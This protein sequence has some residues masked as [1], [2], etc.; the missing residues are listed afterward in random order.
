MAQIFNAGESIMDSYFKGLESRQRD[1]K[2]K[3]ETEIA[4]QVALDRQQKM[5]DDYNRV[6]RQADQLERYQSDVIRNQQAAQ[7]LRSQEF[8]LNLGK[9]VA[10]G[11]ITRADPNVPIDANDPSTYIDN[12]VEAGLKVAA[13]RAGTIAGATANAQVPAAIDK[14][15][16]IALATTPIE[17]DAAVNKAMRI[18]EAVTKPNKVAENLHDDEQK[19]LDREAKKEAANIRASATYALAGATKEAKLD[20]TKNLADA[21]RDDVKSGST[22]LEDLPKGNVG[23]ALKAQLLNEGLKIPTKK[24]VEQF[25]A[26]K[27]LE[28]FHGKIRKLAD[29]I[30]GQTVWSAGLDSEITQR[31]KELKDDLGGMQKMKGETGVFSDKDMI[32]AAG[33][34]PE[35]LPGG[36][37]DFLSD[38]GRKVA[39]NRRADE[40]YDQM[41]QNMEGLTRN[42][43]EE[44]KTAV[45]ERYA[46]PPRQK[47][48]ATKP[49]K[50]L[51][52]YL[53]PAP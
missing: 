26:Q 33:G 50:E 23:V 37:R 27:I 22:A 43:P 17:T 9:A 39:N 38:K 11:T 31:V 19:R 29:I 42:M 21:Y 20:A 7:K 4:N 25:N 16:G 3:A 44:Q 18:N 45:Y 15:R 53:V 8:K 14:A 32:R 6:T 1:Q 12:S 24:Q 36:W 2:L 49:K 48:S 34:I 30:N 52:S 47:K 41:H 51:P 10:D 46:I 28:Q 35:I 40:V 5:T 13:D